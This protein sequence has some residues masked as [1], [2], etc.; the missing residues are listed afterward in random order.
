[1]IKEM[2]DPE[3]EQKLAAAGTRRAT[4]VLDNDRSIEAG[5]E[6]AWRDLSEIRNRRVE[7]PVQIRKALCIVPGR[8][9]GRTQQ[10]RDCQLGSLRGPVDLSGECIHVQV[11]QRVARNAAQLRGELRVQQRGW[12]TASGSGIIFGDD[13]APPK[14]DMGMGT[15]GCP[16]GFQ[17][18][19]NPDGDGNLVCVKV[20]N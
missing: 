6:V 11:I 12:I 10:M 4:A 5:F 9:P 2:W 14:P 18:E 16:D 8:Q 20:S 17:Q 19:P 13:G 7:V 15:N 3:R 1:M